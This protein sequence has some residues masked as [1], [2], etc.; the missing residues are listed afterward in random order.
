MN[1]PR[2]R[3]RASEASVDAGVTCA[4]SDP[5]SHPKRTVGTHA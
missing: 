4:E 1:R 3:T 5:A 2:E